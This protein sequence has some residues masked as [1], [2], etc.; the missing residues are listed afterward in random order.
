METT[1][2]LDEQVFKPDMCAETVKKQKK[3]KDGLREQLR[4]TRLPTGKQ[5]SNCFNA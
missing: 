3:N 4:K 2:K 5:A 1:T